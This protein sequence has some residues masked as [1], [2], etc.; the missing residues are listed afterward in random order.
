MHTDET[1]P[2]LNFINPFRR[3]TVTYQ[4]ICNGWMYVPFP[5]I[6]AM[7]PNIDQILKRTKIISAHWL[8]TRASVEWMLVAQSFRRV[9]SLVLPVLMIHADVVDIRKYRIIMTGFKRKCAKPI[10]RHNSGNT[11]QHCEKCKMN[12]NNWVKFCKWMRFS[13]IKDKIDSNI[14]ALFE[15]FS[16]YFH[17]M[18]G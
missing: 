16:I 12:H 7:L 15:F 11:F 5:T 9:N 2:I 4:A 3:Q 13:I 8:K 17:V 1:K 10:M 6:N 14:V 18:T